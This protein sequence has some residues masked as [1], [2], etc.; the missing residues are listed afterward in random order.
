MDPYGN[1]NPRGSVQSK[2]GALAR[3]DHRGCQGGWTGYAGGA[4]DPAC[5]RPTQVMRLPGSIHLKTCRVAEVIQ[6]GDGPVELE[7]L[8]LAWPQVEEW[9]KRNSAPKTVIQLALSRTCQRGKFLGLSGEAR[10]AVLVSLAQTVPVR[11]PGGGTYRNVLTLVGILSRALGAEEAAYVIH[12]AGHLDKQGQPWLEWA[13][14]AGARRLSQTRIRQRP[15]WAGWRP[16]PNVSTG[17]TD[18]N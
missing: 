7:R 6:W 15:C 12:R 11:V 5:H 1:T 18:Q 13:Y 10:L 3:T 8:G 16:G 17:G 2:L 4:L 9:A 14:G